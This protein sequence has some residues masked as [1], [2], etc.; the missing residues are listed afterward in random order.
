VVGGGPAGA[1][2]AIKLLREARSSGRHIDVRVI[3]RRWRS[4]GV[5]PASG[6]HEGA[7]CP[8]CAGGISPRMS[9]I[10][11]EMG[12]SLPPEIVLERIRSITI[13]SHWKNVELDVPPG[14]SMASVYRGARPM[15]RADR[16]LNF[17]AF[18][19]EQA[20]REGATVLGGEATGI[21]RDR[22][23][24]PRVLYVLS[25]GDPVEPQSLGADLV[26]YAA[27]VNET[28]GMDL[29]NH[30]LVC[31]L[32][33]LMPGFR[34]PTIRRALIFEL[35]SSEESGLTMEGEL[36]FILYGSKD[37]ALELGSMVPK[38]RFVTVALIGRGIEERL[39]RFESPRAIELFLD[40]PQ[41]RR[42]LAH[43]VK[44][45][46]A[47][48]CTPSLVVSGARRPFGDRI[49]VIGDMATSRLY[50]DGIYAAYLTAAALADT[51]LHDGIDR[52]SLRRSY[53]PAVKRLNIDN[54]LGK[55]VFLINAIAF[56]HPVLSRVTYQAIVW[57]RK[58]RPRKDQ[59]L[60][61]I[62]WRI[63]SGDDTYGRILRAM[64]APRALLFLLGGIVVTLRNA[65]TEFVFGLSWKNIGRYPTGM[66]RDELEA[67]VAQLDESVVGDLRTLRDFRRAYSIR[68][69]ASGRA[70]L[71]E[72]GRFGN[73][74]RPYF[75]PRMI[76]VR[77][78]AGQ[79]NQP[80]S[81]LRY[82]VALKWLSF[83]IVL[84]RIIPD[85]C[86]VYRIRDGFAQGGVLIFDVDQRR[87]NDSMLTILAAFRVGSSGPGSR[88]RARRIL[89]R[90]FFPG[91]VHDVLWNHALCRLRDTVE[92][93]AQ[94]TKSAAGGA[95]LRVVDAKSS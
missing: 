15:G 4:G 30:R 72:L 32:Q 6:S 25:T 84:E 36:H 78:V 24:R 12:L 68:V 29:A 60:A 14:R 7:S 85:R 71:R 70:I 81:V 75:R 56:R 5:G 59:Y 11:E 69:K 22:D 54:W 46:M 66:H 47:C 73:E 40:M 62:L 26:V 35:E 76:D 41:V 48:A 1:L 42:E 45:S 88:A 23:G 86:L 21:S 28:P 58:T 83:S 55:I 92:T 94:D 20:C 50:K 39:R 63:A 17:D 87:P 10:L 82:D 95:G 79:P 8:Y 57:E 2:F 33:R 9:D 13:H 67:K 77:Q 65:V 37:L 89:F 93:A 16:H 90:L 80:G 51:V 3:E 49:A 43:P 27:G 91:F 74:D 64:F 19:L 38:G 44:R 31:D 52:R 18:L 61:S 34:V 53:W